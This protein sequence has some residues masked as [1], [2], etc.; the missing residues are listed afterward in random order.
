[1]S[2]FADLN[3]GVLMLQ[4]VTVMQHFALNQIFTTIYA[5]R[6]YLK[7]MNVDPQ[8]S[9]LE[10]QTLVITGSYKEYLEWRQKNAGVRFCKYVE[11]LEDIQGL[12]GFFIDLIFHGNYRDNPAYA[13]PQMRKLIT[14]SE[15][16]FRSYVK[17]SLKPRRN[18]MIPV[19]HK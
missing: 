1:M 19:N 14:E 9:Q 7:F 17:I 16:P 13:T 11:G 2:L 18:S 4:I 10:V 6:T 8:D 3:S 15:S 12:N 5:A